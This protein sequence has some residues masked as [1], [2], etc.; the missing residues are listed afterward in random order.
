MLGKYFIKKYEN[1]KFD[2][3]KRD[4]KNYNE[5]KKWVDNTSANYILHFAAKVSTSM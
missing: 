2:I 5:V 4:I 1:Y 3:F